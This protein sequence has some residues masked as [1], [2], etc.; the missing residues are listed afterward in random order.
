VLKPDFF[1]S[2][3]WVTLNDCNSCT[4]YWLYLYQWLVETVWHEDLVICFYRSGNGLYPCHSGLSVSHDSVF[5]AEHRT[6]HSSSE[7][8]DTAQSSSSLSIQ[9]L[10]L[11]G[12]RVSSKESFQMYLPVTYCHCLLR[13]YELHS[14]FTGRF[15]DWGC[16]LLNP[17]IH[18]Y[19]HTRHTT[20]LYPEP[21]QSSS[22]LFQIYFM[23]NSHTFCSLQWGVH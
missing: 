22:Y 5:T 1:R 23:S 2:V 7:D 19:V 8:L 9:Q 12:V 10:V 3:T 11:P 4:N 16:H 20:D 21:H 13:R 14:A 18:Y 17:W 6:P 15:S